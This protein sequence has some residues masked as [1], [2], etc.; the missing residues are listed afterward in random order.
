M[1]LKSGDV[2]L[3][4]KAILYLL[5]ASVLNQCALLFRAELEALTPPAEDC[6]VVR[7]LSPKQGDQTVQ[8][9][10]VLRSLHI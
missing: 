7:S 5:T 4:C 9:F 1:G 6:R 8:L 3:L 2:Y 10:G